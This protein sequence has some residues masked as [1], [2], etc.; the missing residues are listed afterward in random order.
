MAG[1]KGGS[2]KRKE[3]KVV[4]GRKEK[5]EEGRN[6]MVHVDYCCSFSGWI[7]NPKKKMYKKY[8]SYQQSSR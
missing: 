3:K 5:K 1:K 2:I 8:K 6:D 7:R 4:E